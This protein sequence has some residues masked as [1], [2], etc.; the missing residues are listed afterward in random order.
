MLPETHSMFEVFIMSN[1]EIANKV[2]ESRELSD[3]YLG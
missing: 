2:S 1:P 3:L